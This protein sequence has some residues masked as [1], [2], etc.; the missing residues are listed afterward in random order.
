MD[1]GLMFF[2]SADRLGDN[3]KYRLL[4][5]AARFADNHGFTA[6]W[7]PER[8][9]HEFGGLFPNPALIG[10]ALAMMTE[11]VQIRA[12]SL[13]T[14]LHDPLRVAEEWAV[15]DNLSSGRVA[16][17]FGSGWNTNDFVFFPERYNAR[18]EIVYEHI[19]IVQRLWRGEA[20]ER[21]NG[22]GQTIQIRIYP[23][24]VQK[25]LPVWITTSG[26]PE[27]FSRIGRQG[28]N[29]LTH[30]LGQ[31]ME[32]LAG[33]I[34][35]YRN[36]RE[37]AGFGRHDGIMSLMLHTFVGLEI[38]SVRQT[39]RTPLREY[40]RSAVH[41]E[42]QSAA[43]GGKISGNVDASGEPLVDQDLEELLD[44]AFERYFQNSGLLGTPDTCVRFVQK[45]QEAGVDEVAC[46]I[47]FGLEHDVV[48]RSLELLAEVR[49]ELARTSA[50]QIKNQLAAFNEV[51]Q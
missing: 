33:H 48:M 2:S 43:A 39:V 30:L 3:N 28:A 19:E 1:F 46:L 15:V 44:L 26:N 18:S 5:S 17:S 37:A 21:L 35:Q 10:S 47:D 13:I 14:P 32:S 34:A 29:L 11:H 42:K 51:L 6:I 41:L 50:G 22:S 24:P 31:D 20:V 49:D 27:S 45:L 40:L 4:K 23:R 25:S 7:I 38:Q 9:F 8:H 12:G 36:A 16:V